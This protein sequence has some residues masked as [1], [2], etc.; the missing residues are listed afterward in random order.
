MVNRRFEILR[1]EDL[2]RLLDKALLGLVGTLSIIRMSSDGSVQ[3]LA[4]NTMEEIAY[5]RS[6]IP[7]PS[8]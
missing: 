4:T 5:L 7:P 8:N 6:L 1:H 3:E 2:F